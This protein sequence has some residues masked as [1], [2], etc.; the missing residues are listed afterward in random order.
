LCS[1][2]YKKWK[3]E[4]REALRKLKPPND[5]VEITDGIVITRNV[6]KRLL[7]QSQSD[8]PWVKH[9]ELMD[10]SGT[11]AVVIVA[12]LAICSAITSNL[13]FLVGI[14]IV[15][16]IGILIEVTKNKKLNERAD[17]VNI[18][19]EELAR[20][21]KAKIEEAKI[22]YSSA[23]WRLIR[24]KVIKKQGKVCQECRQTIRNVFDITVDHI[25]PRSIYPEDAL[26]LDNLRVLCRS[27]NSKKGADIINESDVLIDS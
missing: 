17:T 14:P 15:I 6:Q 11:I 20:E 5:N 4:K 16:I 12:V 18:H 10:W 9:Y 27:C 8:T 22:F 21:R 3:Q 7:K 25:R 23:E 26:N 1:E 24:E 13:A 2:C 19:L